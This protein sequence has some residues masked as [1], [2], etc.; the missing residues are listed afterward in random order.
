MKE[1][2]AT[3]IQSL[4]DD[5]RLCK[6]SIDMETFKRW[7][8]GAHQPDIGWLRPV[9][10]ALFGREASGEVWKQ[11]W[12]TRYLN[13]LGYMG[14]QCLIKARRLENTCNEGALAP[15]PQLP[16]GSDSIESWFQSRYPVWLEY[17]RSPKGLVA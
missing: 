15:W 11:Y 17:H 7:S 8:S 4:F 10:D 14:Q 12:A 3:T 1:A 5:P 13:L 6:I 2:G 9:S 16:F